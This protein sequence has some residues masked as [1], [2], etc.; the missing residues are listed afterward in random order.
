MTYLE[1]HPELAQRAVAKLAQQ[2][3]DGAKSTPPANP[4]AP[5]GAANPFAA[6]SSP[7]SPS[8]P[9]SYEAPDGHDAA[10]APYGSDFVHSYGTTRL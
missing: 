1:A 9:Y 4:F 10:A 5:A 6:S 2:P 3:S 7:Y 8:A